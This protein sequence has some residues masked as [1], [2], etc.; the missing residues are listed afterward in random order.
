VGSVRVVT[1]SDA[2]P[3]GVTATAAS[4]QTFVI[5]LAGASVTEFRVAAVLVGRGAPVE[6]VCSFQVARARAVPVYTP[7]PPMDEATRLR[8]IF[9]CRA[10]ATT[11]S[12]F[13]A[14]AAQYPPR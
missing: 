10:K 11:Q 5:D 12:Q 4:A 3:V 2:R 14:C 7:P 13:D 6:L 9:K 8:A 1:G